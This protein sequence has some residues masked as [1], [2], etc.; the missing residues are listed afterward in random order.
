MKLWLFGLLLFGVYA[1]E[2]NED[3][4][5]EPEVKGFLHNVKYSNF[6]FSGL[7]VFSKA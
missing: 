6:E 1:T 4:D 2:N 7:I 3:D 5:H